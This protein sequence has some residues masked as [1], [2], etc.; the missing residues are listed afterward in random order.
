MGEA[1][2]KGALRED[3]LKT[4]TDRLSGFFPLHFSISSGPNVRQHCG[5]RAKGV[6]FGSAETVERITGNTSRPRPVDSK[7]RMCP[8]FWHSCD[9]VVGLGWGEGGG[10]S[11]GGQGG[12]CG[13]Y[14]AAME[15]SNVDVA[16]PV[17]EG[18][19]PEGVQILNDI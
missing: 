5:R 13:I 7:P 6:G 2:V 4:G 9:A 3:S 19:S 15:S 11:G 10:R 18:T 8:P 1:Q 16:H 17:G 14:R 12:I